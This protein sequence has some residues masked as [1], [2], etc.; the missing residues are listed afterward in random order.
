MPPARSQSESQSHND[1]LVTIDATLEVRWVHRFRVT[2]EIFNP[3]NPVFTDALGD[4][5]NG[6]HRLLFVIDRGVS[7]AWP[8]LTNDIR[9]YETSSDDRMMLAGDPLII[10][11]G[12]VCKNSHESLDAIVQAINER[13]ICR[14]SFVVVIGGGAVLDVAGFAAATVH[15]GVRLIRIPTTTLAQA[16]SG[17]GVKNGINALGKK[18]L[19]GTFSPPWAVI[20]DEH[21]LE[22]LTDRDW[23]S[24][25]CECV[26]VA[27]VKDAAFLD[28][29]EAN[30]PLLNQRHLEAA[31][32]IIRRSAELHLEHIVNGGD[33]FELTAARPLDFGHW[34]AHKL[35]HMTNFRLTHGE[36]VAIGMAI[37]ITY[38]MQAELLPETVGE[39]ILNILEKLGFHLHDEALMS[40]DHLFEGLEEFREHLGGRL[41]I[42]MLR[43]IGEQIDIH[44]IDLTAMR[45]AIS[46]LATRQDPAL[47]SRTR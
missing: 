26:K 25:F 28:R 47:S 31:S 14:Q 2:R 23:R 38:S 39:R 8:D 33:P 44:E 7:D 36:A 29:I 12:E 45:Q 22:T 4:R 27:L 21:F 15:R 13:N 41:T 5:E 42:P 32:P 3:S 24:G 35:E 30:I 20:N 9:R 43:D 34:A 40:T 6:P 17:V 18:N 37:D 11:G 16:D 10:P 1:G 46:Q 19:L